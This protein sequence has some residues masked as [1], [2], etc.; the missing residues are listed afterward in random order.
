MEKNQKNGSFNKVAAKIG[1]W[2]LEALKNITAFFIEAVLAICAFAGAIIAVNVMALVALLAPIWIPICLLSSPKGREKLAEVFY[3]KTPTEPMESHP[4]VCQLIWYSIVGEF[5]NTVFCGVLENMWHPLIV[6][7]P[8]KFQNVFIWS[9]KKKRAISSYPTQVQVDFFKQ[10]NAGARSSVITFLSKK[11]C[12]RLWQDDMCDFRKLYVE[13]VGLTADEIKM[14]FC[15]EKI[16][17]VDLNFSRHTPS[18]DV[19]IWLCERQKEEEKKN[20]YLLVKRAAQRNRPDSDILKA[21][22][23]TA[24]KNFISEMEDIV[25]TLAEI[26]I[27][28]QTNEKMSDAKRLKS[29]H[30]NRA[31]SSED[32]AKVRWRNLCFGQK[33]IS[34][35]A[36]KL[37]SEWQYDIFLESHKEMETKALEYLIQKSGGSYLRKIFEKEFE[38]IEASSVAMSY[39]KLIPESYNIFLA[40]KA[41]RELKQ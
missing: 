17:L 41:A 3:V 9:G 15:S 33:S 10:L 37:M 18:K 38:R 7:L 21:V 29:F 8:I 5:F 39:V 1:S 22:Y 24:D 6:L 12:D 31:F 40:V 34:A 2:C 11:A 4:L 20:A 16:F 23:A 35:A 19:L 30:D 27:V 25:A 36:Q 26:E 14:L 13:Q 32:E 28:Q